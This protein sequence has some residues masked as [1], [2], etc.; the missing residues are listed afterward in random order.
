MS[1]LKAPQR[2][3]T[4]KRVLLEGTEKNNRN[5]KTNDCDFEQRA[6]KKKSMWPN[7]GA[8]AVPFFEG[9]AYPYSYWSPKKTIIRKGDLCREK[10]FEA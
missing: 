1:A 10:M 4:K 2:S 8:M 5:R 9:L 6:N 3:D 7:L